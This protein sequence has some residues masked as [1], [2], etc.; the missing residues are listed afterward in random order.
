MTLID[1]LCRPH[2]TH[3]DRLSHRIPVA[4]AGHGRAVATVTHCTGVV[5]GRDGGYF[6][7]NDSELGAADE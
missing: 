5:Q 6:E 3:S 4:A 7:M 1:G 2:L